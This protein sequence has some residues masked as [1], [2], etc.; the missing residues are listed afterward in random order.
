MSK[1]T[2]DRFYEMEAWINQQAAEIERLR[3]ALTKYGQHLYD[4]DQR[5]FEPCSCGL[6]AALGSH[7]S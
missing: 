1:P 3:A 5:A 7:E 4:C 2:A 6:K